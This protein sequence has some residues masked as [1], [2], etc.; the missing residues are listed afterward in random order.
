MGVAP[1]RG[2]VSPGWHVPS[3]L[4]VRGANTA[5][6]DRQALASPEGKAA[7]AD[8]EN[9]IDLERMYNPAF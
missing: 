9:F 2:R 5:H 4:R 6:N 8:T 7:L 1:N 3:K